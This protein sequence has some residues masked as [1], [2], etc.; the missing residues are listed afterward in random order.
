MNGENSPYKNLSKKELDELENAINNITRPAYCKRNPY[1]DYIEM[2]W[3]G[4]EF[5]RIETA[6]REFDEIFSIDKMI[7]GIYS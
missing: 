1:L 2:T 5:K 4:E 3:E 6:A 7:K